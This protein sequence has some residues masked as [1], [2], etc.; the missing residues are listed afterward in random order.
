LEAE[1]SKRVM[2]I[3]NKINSLLAIEA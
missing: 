1:F 3:N 2:E